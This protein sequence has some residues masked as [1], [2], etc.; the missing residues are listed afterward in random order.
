MRVVL[1]CIRVVFSW[2]GTE[3]MWM[4]AGLGQP[5]GLMSEGQPSRAVSTWPDGVVP[6]PDHDLPF[7]VMVLSGRS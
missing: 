5:L 3:R 6:C 1:H 2:S 4:G 7:P